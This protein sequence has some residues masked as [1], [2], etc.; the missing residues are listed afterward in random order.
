[1]GKLHCIRVPEDFRPS[2]AFAPKSLTPC[3]RFDPEGDSRIP[4]LTQTYNPIGW[5]IFIAYPYKPDE[6]Q[7]I[8]QL[9]MKFQAWESEVQIVDDDI[10]EEKKFEKR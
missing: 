6:Q 2:S 8:F 3:G 9:K 10:L 5:N 4:S 7:E 1:M